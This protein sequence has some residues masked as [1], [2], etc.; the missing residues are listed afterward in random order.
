MQ[1]VIIR[2]PFNMK[3]LIVGG[4]I[5]GLTLGAFLE[6]SDIE[7]DIIEKCTDW[8]QQGF[9]ISMWDSGRDI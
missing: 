5:A 7:F 9:L 3:I 4:G 8:N 6:N 2:V 1:H